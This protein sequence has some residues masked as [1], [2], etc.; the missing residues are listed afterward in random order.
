[1]A[2]HVALLRGINVG[3]KNKLPMKD[4]VALFEAA[5]CKNVVTYIQ[6]GN[7][8]F[9]ATAAVAKRISDVIAQAIDE[10]FGLRVPVVTRTAVELAAVPANNPFGSHDLATV[11]VMFLQ[12]VPDADA[13]AGLDSE[14]S[15]GDTFVVHGREI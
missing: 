6:S 13:V 5:G 7:V 2:K 14:R 4:L 9:D 15:K 12:T 1:L 11:H 10:T 3:G 8:V